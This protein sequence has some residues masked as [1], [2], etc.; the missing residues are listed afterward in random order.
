MDY[1]CLR[2]GNYKW[3]EGAL[4]ISAV[5]PVLLACV[6]ALA[7]AQQQLSSEQKAVSILGSQFGLCILE[8]IRQVDEL[9]KQIA[10]LRKQ[11]QAKEQEK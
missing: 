5:M 1:R 7:Q 10:D 9:Q 4:K 2:R 8:S 11:L 3:L 6:P